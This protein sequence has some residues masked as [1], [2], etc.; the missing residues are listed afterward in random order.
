MAMQIHRNSSTG[1][2]QQVKQAA[3]IL[4]TYCYI[5]NARDPEKELDEKTIETKLYQAISL[6]VKKE[7]NS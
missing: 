4:H 7:A 5:E 6:I 1:I 2:S 3:R